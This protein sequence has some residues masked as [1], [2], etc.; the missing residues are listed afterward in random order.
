M[1]TVYQFA[2]SA[3]L[4]TVLCTGGVLP[5]RAATAATYYVATNGHDANA[6]TESGPFSTIRKGVSV[7]QPGDKLYIRQGTYAEGITPASM[8][9]PSGTS[10]S[11]AITISGYPDETVTL[12]GDSYAPIAL[13]S[14]YNIAYLVF[15]H[16]VLDASGRSVGFYVGCGSHHIRLSNSEIRYAGNGVQF[17]NNADYNEIINCSVHDSAYHGLYIMSSN[18]LFDGNQVYNNGGYGYHLYNSGAH[19]VNDNVIRNSEIYGNGSVKISSFGIV[20]GCGS[21]NVMHDNI[22]RD[23]PAGIQVAYGSP[24]ADNTQVYDNTV[25]GNSPGSGIE[26]FPDVTN[27]LVAHNH[28]YGNRRGITDS[29]GIG[30]V[31]SDNTV[32]GNTW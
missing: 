15:E 28:V 13:F 7:L 1:H 20:L 17:C 21:N 9:I 11:D 23:N 14:D 6:G 16:L 29:G 18:N 19:T 5:P 26:I 4:F 2:L 24:P 8:S 12:L 3:T 25:Y 22:V 30:T 32:D 10:W 31:L 27:T